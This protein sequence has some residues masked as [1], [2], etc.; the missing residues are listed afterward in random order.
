MLKKQQ[1]IFLHLVLEFLFLNLCVILV[2]SAKNMGLFAIAEKPE[3]WN[4]LLE[5]CTV[6]N[7]V[8][9]GIILLNRDQ[10]FYLDDHFRSRVK[11]ILFNAFLFIGIN[12]TLAILFKVEYFNRTTFILPIFIFTIL[13]IIF[14]SAL[15]EY[16][17]RKRNTSFGTNILIVGIGERWGQVKDFAQK[18]QEAGYGVVGYLDNEEEQTA[19]EFYTLGKINDLSTVLDTIQVDELFITAATLDGREIKQV[20]GLSDYYGV[21]VNL[22]PETSFFPGSNFKTYNVNGL[23]ILKHRQSPL[24]NFNNLI[25]K[26]VFDILFSI[27]VLTFLSPLF[28]LI[29]FLIKIDSKGTIL[30]LPYR[31]GEGGETFKCYKFR[32]MSVCD[33]PKKGQQSTVKNDPR[34]TRVGKFLRKFDLDELPQFWNVLKGEMSVVGPRPHRVNLQNDFRKIVNDYMVRHYV[35]PGITGWAQVNGWRGPTVT[36]EQKKGRIEHDLWY[37]ENWRFRL[38]LKIIFLTVFSKKTRI[39]AF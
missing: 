18:I 31:K 28:L 19:R 17:K 26:R 32:T 27:A 4:N 15:I 38:D 2:F 21:R 13:N 29:A 16:Y 34:I 14:F 36:L 24:D 7:L 8:W 22:I 10:S 30:Y 39:N 9:A 5:M 37:I 11:Q 33:D 25:F 35:K 1:V 12:S 23:P 6:F 20:V 3:S